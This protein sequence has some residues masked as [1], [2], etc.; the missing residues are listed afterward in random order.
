MYMYTIYC[1]SL[2]VEGGRPDY[3]RAAQHFLKLF[4]SGKMGQVLLDDVG[5]VSAR[6]TGK[7]LLL[8]P[9]H[10]KQKHFEFLHVHVYHAYM[11]IKLFL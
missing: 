11:E 3:L 6:D 1:T 5:L 10:L 2:I 4:R 9:V 7:N 8:A